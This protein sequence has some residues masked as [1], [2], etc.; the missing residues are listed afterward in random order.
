MVAICVRYL[1]TGKPEGGGGGRG[2]GT[3]V[4]NN[5]FIC[6]GRPRPVVTAKNTDY[7]VGVPHDSQRCSV[8]SSNRWIKHSEALG[9]A[10]SAILL[11]VRETSAPSC[12]IA[13][14]RFEAF[15]IAY[16]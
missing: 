13:T 16:D 5:Q 3:I 1:R 4:C 8:E 7:L 15:E 11:A 12:Y 6:T 9:V 2:G 10:S 14:M